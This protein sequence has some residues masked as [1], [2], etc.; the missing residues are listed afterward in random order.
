MSRVRPDFFIIGAPKCGTTAIWTYL[1][2]HPRIFFPSIKEPHYLAT[3]LDDF[4]TVT[5]S[6]FYDKIFKKAKEGQLKGEASVFYLCSKTAVKNI[7]KRNPSAKIIIMLRNP[8]E[9][10]QSLH[11]Q[12]LFTFNETE[13][14]FKKA[15]QLQD[16]RG[17]GKK[18]PK[19]CKSPRLLQYKEIAKFGIQ[20][21]RVFKYFPTSQ[22]HIIF[23]EDFKRDPELVYKRLLDFLDIEYDGRKSFEKINP[24]KTTKYKW[25]GK[26]AHR[27]PKRLV[28]AANFLKNIFGIDELGILKEISE[29]NS[30]QKNREVIEADLKEK[31]INTLT[32]DI[33]KLEE[34]TGKDLSI[35][36]S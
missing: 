32:G 24:G 5:R 14:D 33:N 23:F 35:W 29:I 22:V 34:V 19:T 27:P 36:K 6:E 26:F 20:V 16:D 4:R 30:V 1:R 21:E 10:I 25:L 28:A 11:Q 31:I 13:K 2:S 8:I 17:K 18:I 15:W 7:K 12:L 3:D 9:M